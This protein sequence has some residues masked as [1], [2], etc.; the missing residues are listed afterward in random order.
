MK[1]CNSREEANS[2]CAIAKG[3]TS[4]DRAASSGRGTFLTIFALPMLWPEK[5]RTN[6][7]GELSVVY[8]D[9]N[10]TS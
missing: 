3:Q 7:G 9:R 4:R 6:E 8:T 10:N 2:F 1:A 5:G